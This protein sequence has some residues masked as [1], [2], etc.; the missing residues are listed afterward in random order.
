MKCPDFWLAMTRLM[1]LLL[2]IMLLPFVMDLI[3]F[4]SSE[5][6]PSRFDL[7]CAPWPIP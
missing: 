1:P 3:S 2:L 6:G 4:S 5:G 7:G